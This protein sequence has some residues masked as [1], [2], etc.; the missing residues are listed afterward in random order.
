MVWNVV[1][2]HK[3]RHEGKQRIEGRHWAPPTRASTLQATHSQPLPHHSQPQSRALCG[4]TSYE[5][6]PSSPRK[7]A[8]RWAGRMA[9]APAQAA[10]TCSL[11]G[12]SMGCR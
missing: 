12:V 9:N 11:H 3:W 10:S 7:C 6:A 8:S 1:T 4:L 2:T 5:S